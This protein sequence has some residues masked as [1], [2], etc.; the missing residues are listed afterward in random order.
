LGFS[1]FSWLALLIVTVW[2]FALDARARWREPLASKW[3]EAAQIGLLL[4]TTIA[5]L[6]LVSAIPQGLLGTPDIKIAGYGSTAAQLKWFADRSDGALPVAG[7]VS[8]SLWW[9]KAAMLTWALWLANALLGWLR[10]GWQAWSAGGYWRKP[11]RK[12]VVG[13][14]PPPPKPD[15]AAP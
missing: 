14:A 4:L 9:Y 1:T 11:A 13:G 10:W 6:S 15:D 5:L 3:F 2:L 7:A 12:P 8:V